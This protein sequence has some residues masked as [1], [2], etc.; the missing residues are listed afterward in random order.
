VIN[1]YVKINLAVI[2]QKRNNLVKDVKLKER[3]ENAV[4]AFFNNEILEKNY[5]LEYSHNAAMLQVE[6]SESFVERKKTW[7]NI[8]KQVFLF[9]PA[10]F[11]LFVMFFSTTVLLVDAPVGYQPYLGWQ[12]YAWLC[13]GVFGTW[14]G[15]G[16]IKKTK[17]LVIPFSVILTSLILALITVIS[18][19]IVQWMFLEGNVFLFFP[20]VL[21]TPILAKNLT[22][23]STE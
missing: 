22:D 13:F 21:I 1:R 23:N 7:L 20:L 14:F 15:L 17:H 12:F 8:L 4:E 6:E 11:I 3:L 10:A 9:F 18:P 5:S 16:D 2:P 19:V